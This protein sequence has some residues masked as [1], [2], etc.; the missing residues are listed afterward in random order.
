VPFLNQPQPGQA[1]GQAIQPQT[2]FVGTF[3]LFLYNEGKATAKNVQVGHF[4]QP[5]AHSVY[6]DISRRDERTPGGGW[7]IRLE[8]VPPRTVVMISYLTTGIFNVDQILSYVGW[9]D[10]AAKKIPV[11]LQRIWPK[12]WIRTGVALFYIGLW[13]ILNLAVTLIEFL[14]RVYYAR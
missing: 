11:L 9:E 7:L 14:W 6:P 12:W 1:Q 4:L 10:G 2:N 8:F 3:T 13:V 5:F